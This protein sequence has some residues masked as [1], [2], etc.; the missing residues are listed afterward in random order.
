MLALGSE[1]RKA[2][3]HGFWGA[4]GHIVDGKNRVVSQMPGS[5]AEAVRLAVFLDGHR[6]TRP[7]KSADGC[8]KIRCDPSPTTTGECL[9]KTELANAPVWCP[10]TKLGTWV[11][12]QRG[13]I[14]LTGN[15]INQTISDHLVGDWV[16]PTISL[17]QSTGRL[18]VTKPGLTVVGKRKGKVAE[19][20]VFLP[21]NEDHV[22]ISCDL[23]QIDARV[24]AGLSQDTEY[25]KMF[26]P[27][28]DLHT[29]MAVILFN[30][31]NRREE[32]KPVVHGYSYGMRPRKLAWTTGISLEEA[33]N[34]VYNLETT[35]RRLCQWQ[36]E[37]REIGEITGIL[38]NGYGRQLKIEADRAFTQSP[39]LLGQSTA[40]DVLCEGVL[41]LWKTG[42]NDVI[43]MIKG[44]IHDEVILSCHKNDVDEIEHLVVDALTFD[45]CPI[46]GQYSVPITAGLNQRG[47]GNWADCYRKD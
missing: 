46:G 40:R 47:Y 5:I 3:I 16:H 29:E 10:T 12:R 1:E 25:L 13:Q 31:P 44:I 17:R 43:K 34:V 35:L 42:G 8:D 27:G 26:E 41:N 33:E 20:A 39:A 2:F 14:C 32:A 19:R 15:S 28:R 30:D 22:L 6:A 4:E 9:T 45:W 36:E 37:V 23:S 21:D 7:N 24:V 18:S 11:M 38:Y